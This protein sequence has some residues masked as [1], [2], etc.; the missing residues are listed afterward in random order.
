MCAWPYKILQIVSQIESIVW[1]IIDLLAYFDR[2]FTANRNINFT[3]NKH[4]QVSNKH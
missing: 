4:H 1:F 2:L 3:W